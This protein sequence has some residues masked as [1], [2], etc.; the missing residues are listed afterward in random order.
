[1]KICN[2]RSGSENSEASL[3][4]YD[5]PGSFF[6]AILFGKIRNFVHFSDAR[7]DRYCMYQLR[8]R[9]FH[10]RSGATVYLLNGNG[11]LWNS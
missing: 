7:F 2:E 1:M 4:S 3:F 5:A 9:Q 10:P 8:G 11:R 6:R